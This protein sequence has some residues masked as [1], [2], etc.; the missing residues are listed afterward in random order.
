MSYV[1]INE[2]QPGTPLAEPLLNTE[3][4]LI[5]NRGTLLTESI[6]NR[7]RRI[8]IETLSISTDPHTLEKENQE[9]LNAVEERFKGMENNPFLQELK[10]L[11]LEHLCPAETTSPPSYS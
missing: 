3:G 6:L 1:P 8:G 10:R 9:L 5:L 7:L 4:S 2:I 11:A